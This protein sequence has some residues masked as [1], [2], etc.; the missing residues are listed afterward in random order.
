MGN[1]PNQ[2]QTV[3]ASSEYKLDDHAI[4]QSVVLKAGIGVLVKGTVLGRKTADNLFYTY[5]DAGTEGEEVARGILDEKVDTT[6][7]LNK[8]AAMMIHGYV[9]EDSLTAFDAAA[10][11]DMAGRM[12]FDKTNVGLDLR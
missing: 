7:S 12:I 5:T 3:Q 2:V 1:L 6:G 9:A 8:S 4:Y 10:A 11:V